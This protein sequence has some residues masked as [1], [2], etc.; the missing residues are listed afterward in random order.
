[1]CLTLE[2]TLVSRVGIGVFYLSGALSALN[3]FGVGVFKGYLAAK[4]PMLSGIEFFAIG[5]AAVE[6]LIGLA[7]HYL[8]SGIPPF[9]PDCEV[10]SELT[11]AAGKGTIAANVNL[12]KTG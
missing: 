5:V 7:V 9:Q 12:V 3:L 11:R 2:L 4:S 10:P 1:M 6:Y 8:F